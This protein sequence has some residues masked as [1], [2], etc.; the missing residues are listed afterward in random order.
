MA[1][2]VDR[3]FSVGDK[4][5]GALRRK[6]IDHRH[7]AEPLLIAVVDDDSAYAEESRGEG[8]APLH[9]LKLL[10]EMKSVAAIPSML[11]VIERSDHLAMAYSTAIYALQALGD[12]A[13]EPA[14]AAYAAA[15]DDEFRDPLT[16]VLAGLGVRDERIFEILVE[17]LPLERTLGAGNLVTYGDTRAVAHLQRALDEYVF[18]RADT[19]FANHDV[20][21]LAAAIEDLGGELSPSQMRKLERVRAAG[22]RFRQLL[23]GA[24]TATYASDD[25]VDGRVANQPGRNDPCHCGS[26]KKYKKCHLREDENASLT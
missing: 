13:V 21:E 5:P 6:I 12:H 23:S 1:S 20:I 25:D 3:L 14:L 16:E 9:A 19:P 4:L 8:Y 22:D 11:R 24:P 26:G 18:T 17:R 10:G 2:I 15:D 7:E